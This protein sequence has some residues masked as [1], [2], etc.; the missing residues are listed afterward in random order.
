[1]AHNQTTERK[2]RVAQLVRK[3][4]SYGSLITF[5]YCPFGCI[6]YLFAADCGDGLDTR[7]ADCRQ[8]GSGA[9]NHRQG[10]D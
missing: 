7:C 1:M 9:R 6:A 4:T 5:W 3:S 8:K 10:S 2:L